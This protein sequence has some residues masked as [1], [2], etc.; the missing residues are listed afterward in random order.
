[1]HWSLGDF[2]DDHV[3][4]QRQR[5]EL[6][7]LRR[8]RENRVA[9]HAWGAG[10]RD[11]TQVVRWRGIDDHARAIQ[12]GRLIVRRDDARVQLHAGEKTPVLVA[13]VD[14]FGDVWLVR[15]QSDL[16]SAAGEQIGERGAPCAGPY[17]RAARHA[18]RAATSTAS[19]TT[20][21][22]ATIAVVERVGAPPFPNRFSSPRRSRPMFARCV[23]KTKTDKPDSGAED[24]NDV[25]RAE[26][27]RAVLS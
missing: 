26:I 2:R 4:H 11:I 1:Y 12:R 23:Q 3:R 27:P 17:H 14:R 20:R 18:K 8:D 13:V 16:V 21:P 19:T 24:A 6:D 5:A 22:M 15:P 10:A 25:R 9:A 7:A